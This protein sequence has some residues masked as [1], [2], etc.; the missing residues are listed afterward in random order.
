MD[1]SDHENQAAA[2]SQDILGQYYAYIFPVW[3]DETVQAY[4]SEG[5]KSSQNLKESLIVGMNN[6]V[7]DHLEFTLTNYPD[8]QNSLTLTIHNVEGRLLLTRD[9]LYG[10]D[11]V[12]QNVTSLTSGFYLLSL[13]REGKV[14]DSRLFEKL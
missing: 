9:F 5:K 13:S 8:G 2:I 12:S 3:I 10:H 4:S 7:A 6:P 14:I 1:L 11:K